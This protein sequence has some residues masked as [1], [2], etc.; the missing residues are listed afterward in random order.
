MAKYGRLAAAVSSQFRPAVVER[1]GACCDALVGL[2][3]MLC[4]DRHRDA[5]RDADYTFSAASRSTYAASLLVF[6]V[7]MADASM[8]ERVVSMDV[9]DAAAARY[10]RAP[11][12]ARYPV[13]EGSFGQVPDARDVEGMGGRFWYEAV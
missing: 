8:V 7:V 9:A 3:S 13:G 6:S 10:A 5:L 11:A 1:F 12:S 2:V 4:G